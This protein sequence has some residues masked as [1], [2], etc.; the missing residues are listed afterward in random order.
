[1]GGQSKPLPPFTPKIDKKFTKTIVLVF[2]IHN[3]L[4]NTNN[5]NNNR[6]VN[7]PPQVNDDNI[8]KL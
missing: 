7:C 6:C 4:N 8:P 5:L 3:N 1:M 2:I